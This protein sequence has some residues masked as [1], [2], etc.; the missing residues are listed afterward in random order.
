MDRLRIVRR[1][2]VTLLVAALISLTG[3]IATPAP[4]AQA[5]PITDVAC[6]AADA[7]VGPVCSATKA[8]GGAA[9][10]AV[11]D[12]AS[13]GFKGIVKSI[14]QGAGTAMVTV[15]TWFVRI[16][17][18]EAAQ[19]SAIQ[20]VKELTLRLQLIFMA[21]S[22]VIGAIRLMLAK[23]HAVYAAGEEQF[24]AMGRAVIGAWMF[25][26]FLT[27]LSQG[28]DALSIAWLNSVTH[29]D[30]PSKVI[31]RIVKVDVL[32]GMGSGLVLIVA[33]LGVLGA[34]F[35]AVV[36]VVRQ[37]MLILVTAY[38]PI[39]GAASGTELGKAA[40][41]KTVRWVI[42]LLLWK[43]VAASCFVA[44]F[45]LAGASGA[46]DQAQVL[47][48]FILLFLS[49]LVLPMLMKLVSAG[50]SM[51][52]GSG[53]AAGAMVAGVV[54]AG[55][56]IAASGGAAAAGGGAASTAG[57]SGAAG[58]LSGGGG[59]G[60][61]DGGGGGGVSRMSGAGSSEGAGAMA[62]G[63]SSGGGRGPT[64]GGGGGEMSGASSNVPS[65]ASMPPP[66]SSSGGGGS[67]S[68]GGGGNRF[69]AAGDAMAATS[70][71]SQQAEAFFDSGDDGMGA[72]GGMR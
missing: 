20:K 44:A 28:T 66:D 52:G 53:L 7:A 5:N 70:V 41:S 38:I 63:G 3:A 56:T 69:S 16:P 61:S 72:E 46:D 14:L 39:M 10:D 49:A 51:S 33:I 9:K 25:G 35:Q 29:G 50:L 59:G 17:T 13:D 67:S 32:M 42:A 21:L 60:G 71:M 31:E 43:L 6:A 22:I 58:G 27:A 37:A 11:K 48:G 23:R 45:T 18:P 24:Q 62:S 34:I 15:L 19:Y 47:Y 26:G 30:A 1:A 40:Y 54:A 57:Q 36:L 68:G 4:Q 64:S 65:A 8:V 2:V 12:A 55:G